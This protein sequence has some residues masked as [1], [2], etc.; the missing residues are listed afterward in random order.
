V[1]GYFTLRSNQLRLLLVSASIPVAIV[2]NIVRVLVLLGFLH[3]FKIYL[4][5]GA[6]HTALGLI[7]FGVAFGLFVIIQRGLKLCE[8]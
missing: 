1:F 3:H 2:V 8:R 4:V 7:L 6:A 5:E